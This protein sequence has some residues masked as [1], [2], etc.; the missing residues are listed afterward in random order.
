VVAAN[1]KIRDDEIGGSRVV[2]RILAGLDHRGKV[3]KVD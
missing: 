1:D 3:W 2:A